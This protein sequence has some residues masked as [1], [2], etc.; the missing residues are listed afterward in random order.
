MTT[1]TPRDGVN[2]TR[3]E[4]GAC[5]QVD[6]YVGDHLA[7]PVVRVLS[8]DTDTR[9]QVRISEW[10]KFVAEVKNGDW[11]HVDTDYEI[12]TARSQPDISAY[13]FYEAA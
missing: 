10:R 7:E 13:T 4:S 3:C 2:T 12:A 1:S 5:V 6:I 8:T 9:M 11:D